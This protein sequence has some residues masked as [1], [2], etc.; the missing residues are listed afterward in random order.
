MENRLSAGFRPFSGPT[1]QV[2]L[3]FVLANIFVCHL[4]V[5]RDTSN[6]ILRCPPRGWRQDLQL[7]AAWESNEHSPEICPQFHPWLRRLW[8]APSSHCHLVA[9]KVPCG[10]SGRD[11]GCKTAWVGWMSYPWHLVIP[12]FATWTEHQRGMFGRCSRWESSM[13]S[14]P[15]RWYAPA[16]R[17]WQRCRTLQNTDVN[18]C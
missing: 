15:N 13:L 2:L 3:M 10:T 8:S 6:R 7:L 12:S 18:V 5:W 16:S 1:G 14:C 9:N 4:T 17:L 11:T